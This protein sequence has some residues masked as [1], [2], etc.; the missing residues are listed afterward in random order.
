MSAYDLMMMKFRKN[1]TVSPAQKTRLFISAGSPAWAQVLFR[2]QRMIA[3]CDERGFA[4]IIPDVKNATD[5]YRTASNQFPS[6]GDGWRSQ[7]YLYMY[8]ARVN[9]MLFQFQQTR[10]LLSAGNKMLKE[11]VT[12]EED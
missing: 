4:E 11:K 9:L 7:F 6:G 12:Q 5:L 3:K 10:D 1:K 8:L 2:L